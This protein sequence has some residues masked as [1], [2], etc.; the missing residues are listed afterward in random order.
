[1]A[2]LFSIH[3]PKLPAVCRFLLTVHHRRLRLNW[4]G[5]HYRW[6]RH[7]WNHVLF[8]DELRFSVH[9]ADRRLQVWRRTGDS[10]DE[11]NI[12]ERNRCGSGSVMILGEIL[13]CDSAKTELVTVNA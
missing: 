13:I 7:R 4:A 10:M 1:M 3:V 5:G 2:L 11:N 8:T 12:V 6:S 9:F